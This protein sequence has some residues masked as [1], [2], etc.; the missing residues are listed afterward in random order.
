MNYNV[1]I[2]TNEYLPDGTPLVRSLTI[3]GT[4]TD[5]NGLPV[6]GANIEIIEPHIN[7]IG[8]GTSEPN[9]TFVVVVGDDTMHHV[10]VNGEDVQLLKVL[11]NPDP[12]N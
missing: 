12:A 9:G 6:G 7:D 1:K 11:T 3:T 8:I 4:I 2:N 5:N 10:W